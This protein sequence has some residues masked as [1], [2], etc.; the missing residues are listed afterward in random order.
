MQDETVGSRA[1][2]AFAAANLWGG[3]EQRDN[4]TDL[5][6]RLIPSANA[7][8]ANAVLGAFR[9]VEELR[10]DGATVRL[11]E[12]LAD[13]SHVIA[14]AGDSFLIERLESLLPHEATLVGRLALKI[15]ELWKESLGDI[16]TSIAATTPQLVNLALTLHRLGGDTRELGMTLFEKLLEAQAYGAREALLQ[17]DRPLRFSGGNLGFHPRIRRSH[18]NAG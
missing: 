11:L 5:L 6:V 3:P 14:L 16:R 1:G 18:R 17:I 2:L 4:A 10:P 7:A 12:C 8:I 13:H 15:V 9:M